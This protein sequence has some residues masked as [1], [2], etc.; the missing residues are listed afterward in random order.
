MAKNFCLLPEQAAKLSKA[1]K[2][3][4][5]DMKELL[6]MSHQELADFF[7]KFAPGV[8]SEL[9]TIFESKI[10]LKNKERGVINMFSKLAQQGKY[11]PSEIARVNAMKDEYM[12]AKEK[13]ILSPEEHETFLEG[14]AKKHVGSTEITRE[15]ANKLFD[16]KEKA[17]RILETKYN[18]ETMEWE[19]PEDL[20]EYGTTQYDYLTFADSLADESVSDAI[21]GF[22]REFKE[23]A[24]DNVSKAVIDAFSAT[25]KNVSDVIISTVGSVDNS[26]VGRQGWKTLLTGHPVI[27]TRA[28]VKSFQNIGG[29]L[30]GEDMLRL[31]MGVFLARPNAIN[32]NYEKYKILVPHEETHPT[33]LPGKV[34]YVGRVFTA[35]ETAFK[36]SGLEMRAD[37]F[38]LRER[39]LS[40]QGKATEKN[41]E[42]AA[43][44]IMSLTGRGEWRIFTSSPIVNALLWAPRMMVG[45]VKFLTAHGFG[46]GLS[47][48]ER[49]EAFKD[50]FKFAA[51]ITS[52]GGILAG[53]YGK[54]NIELNPISSDF[55]KLTVEDNETNRKI[56]HVLDFMGFSTNAYGG[57]IRIDITGGT[58]QYITLVA[59]VITKKSKSSTTDIITD[60]APGFGKKSRMDVIMSFLENKLSPFTRIVSDTLQD[61]DFE[62]RPIT[63][64]GTMQSVFVPISIQNIIKD[65]SDSPGMGQVWENS[66]SKEMANFKNRVGEK[67]FKEA[68]I[69]YI[70]MYNDEVNKLTSSPSYQKK[71]D[72]EKQKEISRIKRTVK[73][74]ILSSY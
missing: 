57:K 53:I 29:T 68:N 14:L 34:P 45:N 63:V 32:G 66:E 67:K 41:L 30:K 10:V 59:R 9:A 65:V 55:G 26:F 31:R 70:R 15:E 2:E 52:I 18:K 38:D 43:K 21:S 50:L 56:A 8:G 71:T 3:K 7:E 64:G 16:L 60:L 22:G 40:A 54:E 47:G 1:L 73:R 42:S 72:E 62:G 27:W 49:A 6:S 37:L 4:D 13:R 33:S 5:V 28:L 24:K 36:M 17:D 51:S 11:S 12:K 74:R 19:S 69:K 46:A 58:G 25:V 39:I 35:S 44:R 48:P 20:I 61:E 23:T